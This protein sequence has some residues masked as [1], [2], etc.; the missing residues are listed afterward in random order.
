MLLP[1][2]PSRGGRST[3]RGWSCAS[4]GPSTPEASPPSNYVWDRLLSEATKHIEVPSLAAL[5]PAEC[6]TFA[7]GV[8]HSHDPDRLPQRLEAEQH[9]G[10]RR[11]R[12]PGHHQP[13]HDQTHRQPIRPG[14]HV[15]PH[16]TSLSGVSSAT[17][18]RTAAVN[19]S[20]SAS[21]TTATASPAQPASRRPAQASTAEA[22]MK[23][24]DL[25]PPSRP[26]RL[27]HAQHPRQTARPATSQPRPT[28][29]VAESALR[30]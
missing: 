16:S 18:R 6:P 19:S 24:A 10:S 13:P 29:C 7:K 30:E 15:R 21:S 3:P 8:R 1:A 22:T 20:R 12:Q 26:T 23:R 11:R 4:S 14:R 5:F 25:Q 17:Q 9:P 28:C 27:D 2:P